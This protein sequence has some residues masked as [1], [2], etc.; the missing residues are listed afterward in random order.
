[1]I[2][3]FNGWDINLDDYERIII[4][5][6]E[7]ETSDCTNAVL[8]ASNA[9]ISAGN[10]YVFF[11]SG[12]YHI[13]KYLSIS[14]N[15]NSAQDE[16]KLCIW[17]GEDDANIIIDDF[18]NDENNSN[19]YPC[20]I[21][22]NCQTYI[23]NL[24]INYP[25]KICQLYTYE[26]AQYAVTA[27]KIRD[28]YSHYW[29]KVKIF[30][31]TE[32]DNDN[33]NARAGAVFFDFTNN[34]QYL[35]RLELNNCE[36]KNM[37]RKAVV[38]NGS[39]QEISTAL[40]FIRGN[41]SDIVISG[42]TFTRNH[43][44][45]MLTIWSNLAVPEN[46]SSNID[47][48]SIND[49]IWY[50][51][52]DTNDGGGILALG[53]GTNDTKFGNISV[54]G[55]SFYAETNKLK[56]FVSCTMQS[57]NGSF[58]ININNCNF[59]A[60]S[61]YTAI[62]TANRD[63]YCSYKFQNCV[64]KNAGQTSD[65]LYTIG[66]INSM[67]TVC[68][69]EKMLYVD[70]TSA[71]LKIEAAVDENVENL[72]ENYSKSTTYLPFTVHSSV[73]LRN[74]SIS[75]SNSSANNVRLQIKSDYDFIANELIFNFVD[76][77]NSGL[78]DNT[79]IDLVVTGSNF[80]LTNSKLHYIAYRSSEQNDTNNTEKLNSVAVVNNIIKESFLFYLF[81]PFNIFVCSFNKRNE[82]DVLQNIFVEFK[83]ADNETIRHKFN[84]ENQSAYSEELNNKLNFYS[85]GMGDYDF[86]KYKP[87]T[88]NS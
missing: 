32:S 9:A 27:V 81:R 64:Y 20:H 85:I 80:T 57:E 54:S 61:A 69:E 68:G 50:S 29:E 44:S 5:A 36:F 75:Y 66:N 48:V 15:G 42:C 8:E 73:T 23:K 41:F 12:N 78:S 6:P 39:N 88:S 17:V 3:K 49:C 70:D 13:K 2:I 47:N 19:L 86:I 40:L 65:S 63:C 71:H 28:G 7:G 11:K 22:F 53:N 37:T 77:G 82:N 24:N 33:K 30:V 58:S 83:N 60:N 74:A 4:N 67:I 62:V 55:C 18:D 35:H 25:T 21:N 56:E 16:T 14:G 46:N 26:N 59:Y 72:S 51:Y 45:D 76:D 10:K 34:P 31:G 1:M 52:N 84:S 79:H 38:L 87:T 43:R